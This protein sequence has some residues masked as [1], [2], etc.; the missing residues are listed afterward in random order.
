MAIKNSVSNDFLSTFVDSIN[1]FNCHLS[2]VIF[3]FKDLMEATIIN[4]LCWLYQFSW[5]KHFNDKVSKIGYTYIY[6][7]FDIQWKLF[8][9]TFFISAKFFTS[10]VFAQMYQF[11]LN[12]NT[13]QQ[14]FSFTSNYLGTN[15]VVVKRVDCIS[16]TPKWFLIDY[17]MGC[18]QNM[19]QTWYGAIIMMH[20]AVKTVLC[21]DVVSC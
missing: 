18:F 20:H 11:S 15:S 2:S 21:S 16:Y 9:T 7:T 17:G 1:I 13:L 12:L 4:H 10:I 8:T 3:F 6:T 19:H 14:K 5:F